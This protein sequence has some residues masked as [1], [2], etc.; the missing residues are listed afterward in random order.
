MV[1]DA[2]TLVSGTSTAFVVSAAAV[3]PGQVTGLTLDA[4][5]D[6]TQ[7]LSWTAPSTGTA[8]FTYKVERSTDNSTWTTFAAAA[9]GTSIT[10]T[11][12]TASTLYYYRVSATNSVSTGTPSSVV[13]GSTTAAPTV[14]PGQVTGLAAGTSTDTTQPLSWTAVS[15]ATSYTV[16]RSIAGANSWTANTGVTGTSYTVTGLTAS[17]SYDYRVTAVNGAG[18]GT[19]STIVTNSTA[20]AAAQTM[21]VTTPST[22][23]A[24]TSYTLAGTWT[25]TAPTALEYSYADNGG[26][27]TSWA[28]LASPT[29]ANNGNGTGTW[30]ATVTPTTYSAS[31]VMSVRDATTKVA[32][33]SA[34][35]VVQS[36]AQAF[37]LTA[38]NS[39]SGFSTTP[40]TLTNNGGDLGTSQANVRVNIR[41]AAGTLAPALSSVK[42]AWGKVGNATPPL[43]YGQDLPANSPNGNTQ[44]HTNGSTGVTALGGWTPS[45]TGSQYYGTCTATVYLWGTAGDYVLWVM[46]ADG[47]YKAYDNNT[48]TPITWTVS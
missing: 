23:V 27:S 33:S 7:A 37:R 8:P 14:A 15:G 24:Y 17:T 42:F 1:R 47:S 3:A 2:T 34:A 16:E 13:Q 4:V 38:T 36:M 11:G 31:R 22:Q 41:N 48:G 26:A 9:S 29:I 18:S 43:V 40:G 10:V 19:P 45:T 39:A 35:Y 6:T 12:L 5:T 20:A 46:Y 30:S 25:G 28:T 44:V 21:T 32:G